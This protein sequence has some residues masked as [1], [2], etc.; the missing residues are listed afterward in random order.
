M[1][2]IA[3]EMSSIGAQEDR[4]LARCRAGDV[5]AFG[6]VYARWERPLFRYAYWMMGDA[7]EADDVKQETFL[8]AFRS[9][10]SFDGRCAVHTWLFGICANICKDKMKQRSRR[11]EAP[12]TDAITMADGPEGDPMHTVMAG[13]DQELILK[14]LADLPPAQRE[15][16][17]LREVEG[18]SYEEIRAVFR[19][20]LASVKLRLFRARQQWRKRYK[21]ICDEGEPSC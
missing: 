4:L 18:L 6:E 21:L 7:D 8:R 9:F 20:S 19:C 1:E 5:D 12:L 10:G 13:A 16:L 17:L 14:A 15:L 11:P 2:A 3:R